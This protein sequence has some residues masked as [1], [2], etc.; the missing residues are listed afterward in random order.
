MTDTDQKKI[1]ES[2]DLNETIDPSIKPELL[3]VE[4]S[5]ELKKGGTAV[6]EEVIET[7]PVESKI[8]KKSEE[9][10]PEVDPAA[11]V[12]KKEFSVEEQSKQVEEIVESYIPNPTIAKSDR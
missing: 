1:D 9:S 4:L 6:I 12:T 3:G 5:E 10:D 11:P 2:T 7:A 8:E